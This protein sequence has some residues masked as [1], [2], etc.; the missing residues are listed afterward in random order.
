[1]EAFATTYASCQ[2]VHSG[3]EVVK[4]LLETHWPHM[5]AM[6]GEVVLGVCMDLHTVTLTTAWVK[7]DVPRLPILQ[8]LLTQVQAAC[9]SQHVP[10]QVGFS[11]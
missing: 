3:E 6:G 7:P 9:D 4:T 8:R 1:M 5:F 2:E 11:L 10:M